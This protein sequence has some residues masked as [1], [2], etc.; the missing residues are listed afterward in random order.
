MSN[1][2]KTSSEKN[3]Q[4][5]FIRELEKYKWDSPDYLD[6]N[7]QKVTVDDLVINWRKELNRIN[8][9]QLEGVPLT[10]TEFAQV[11]TKVGQIDNSFE[12]AKILAMEGSTGKIDGI[13]RDNNPRVTRGQ[14]TLTIFKKA[15]V[16][17][18]DSSYKVAR[19]VQSAKGNRFDIV[20]L[21][22]G[23]PLINIEQKRADKTFD[24]AFG[25]FKRYYRDGEY[26]NNFMA[27]SQMMVIMSEVVTR[28]FA[29]PK[30][31]NDFNLSFVF[32]WAD[33]YNK[34]I[35]DWQDVVKYFLM[36]PMAHQL[37]GDYLIIDEAQ[38]EENRRHMIMRPY[39]VYALQA[40]EGA[41]F[42]WDNDGVPHGGYVW[43]T[44]GSGKTITSFKT[45][46]FL[47]TRGGFDKVVFL[48]DRRELDNRTSENFKA[49]AA[50]ESVSVDDTKHTYHLK[51]QL[52][53]SKRGIIV[54]TTF[55]LHILIKDLIEAEDYSLSDKRIIFIIDEAHRTT[56]GQMMGTIKGFFKKNGLFY[57][58]TGT[59]LFDENKTTGVINEQSEVIDT[60]EKLFGPELHRYTIDEAISDG[61]VLGFH[62][63]YINTGEFLSHEDLRQQIADNIHSEKPDRPIREIERL[64]Q[65]L[66][67]A[68][69]EREATKRNLLVYQ[70]QT[71]IP[72]VVKEILAN[73]ESQSQS[74]H[75]NGILTV[76]YKDRVHA[77]YNEF[78][79]ELE[80]QDYKINVAM[81][82]SFGSENE[83]ADEPIERIKTMFKDYSKFT[84]IEFI[85]GDNKKGEQAYFEDLVARATRGGSGRN[86]K[87]IDLIIVAD[88]LLTGYDSKFLN[89]L[90]VDR[91][92]E[93]QGLIQAYSRT[94]RV[95][96]KTKE[97]GTIINFKYP[98]ITEELVN[99]ALKLYGSGGKSSRVIVEHYK[100]AV[101]KYALK[102]KE[103]I[104]ALEDP[105]EWELLKANE[106]AKELFILSF[107]AANDQLRLV[108]Q[109]YEFEW[110][111]RTFSIDEHT[112]LKYVGAYKNL[113][114]KDKE[115]AD[116]VDINPLIGKT[117][118]SGTQVIDANHILSLIGSKI[119]VEQG[120]QRVDDETLRIIHEQIQE[121]SNM[122]EDEQAKLL[123]EF[124]D[125]ELVPG[126]LS[127]FLNFDESFEA[128]KKEKVEKEVQSFA[129]YWGLDESILYKS[130]EHYSLIKEDEIPYI[131]ELSNSVDYDSAINKETGN[132]LNHV[133]TLV[134]KELPEWM[135][136]TKRKYK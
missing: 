80:K 34:P 81:T 26:V 10:D 96:G 21:I 64:V 109:Y 110:D 61:N 69:V 37:V 44:T 108:M 129:E 122:G 20:L 55:K 101:E 74:K 41:A 47:S 91:P 45:A 92:L 5:R 78:K 48:V 82:F 62:V 18:G 66:S 125:T 27:F 68:E 86:P 32:Q 67:K 103:M 59:P 105:T 14:V 76:A 127:S 53:S 40:V 23:L 3:F 12:A 4:E 70:D 77:Y 63:D 119:K 36:I 84:G 28:Y 1:Q 38:D 19:E 115:P 50:Y 8:A 99:K 116:D 100:T 107:R 73:W 6:G 57:G 33:K 2:Q 133:M 88:Q 15:E 11:L 102:V 97:F 94:N 46:L 112:W 134:N 126:K 114:F 30:S 56:M 118:L 117:K 93:Q 51:K 71:H 31:I 39:Q 75:F 132:R 49:Y 58:F 128:W 22:N 135:M 104:Q 54:T 83:V 113:I 13:Y 25:Q 65:E 120:I 60:T 29:T 85:S 16:R 42:G 43:H 72:Q 9:D 121:L 90:Y 98:A 79:K 130:V 35:N 7:K 52:L 111:D 89:T 136:E 106:K 124:V 17:G 95:Y 24:E 131:D 87:N 123:K